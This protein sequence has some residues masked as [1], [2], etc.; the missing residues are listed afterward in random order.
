MRTMVRLSDRCADPDD[1][2]CEV[3]VVD[4]QIGRLTFAEDMA[5]AIFH[6]LGTGAPFGTYNLTC[7]GDPASWADIARE[8]FELRNGNG[9]AV[10]PVTTADY[11]ACAEAAPIALRPARSAFD[12]RKLEE[13]GFSCPIG[14]RASLVMC[15]RSSETELIEVRSAERMRQPFEI[16]DL[17][18]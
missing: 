4:D 10:K 6:L 13:T 7:S 11:Y 2:L 16:A 12:L 8:V 15:I 9:S 14:N 1:G 3:S 18:L 17:R 5:E